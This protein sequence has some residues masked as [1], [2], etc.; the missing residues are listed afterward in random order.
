MLIIELGSEN[1]KLKVSK[2]KKL[3]CYY[4]VQLV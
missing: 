2:E 4:D 3:I 1:L